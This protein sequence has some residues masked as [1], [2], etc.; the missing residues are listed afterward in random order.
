MKIYVD[1]LEVLKKKEKDWNQNMLA[2]NIYFWQ[3]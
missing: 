2:L 1:Y 3:F